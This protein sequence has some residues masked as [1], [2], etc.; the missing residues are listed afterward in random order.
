MI[1]KI[2][3]SLLV[4]NCSA[5]FA[6]NDLT[7]IQTK[8]QQTR[9]DLKQQQVSRDQL[10]HNLKETENQLGKLTLEQQKISV[11][12]K[13]L[14]A[15]LKQ[16]QQQQTAYEAELADRRADLAQ[17]IRLAYMLG[18]QPSLKL[19]LSHEDLTRVGR[20]LTYYQYVSRYQAEAVMRLNGLLQQLEQNQ[21]E[22]ADKT[23]QLDKLAAQQKTTLAQ[24]G[25]QKRDRTQSLQQLEGNIQSKNS[26]LQ[27]L[28]ADKAALEEAV[29]KANAATQSV[30]GAVYWPVGGSF[31]KAQGKLSWP[32]RGKL[33][34]GFDSKLAQSE[35]KLN[36]VLIAAAEGQP[37]YSV[38]PGRVAFAEW[39]SGYGLLMIV[40][41]GQGYMTLY[42][43]NGTLYKKVG[44]AVTAG[45]QIATV[46]KTGGYTQPSLYFAIRQQGTA[47]NPQAW[48]R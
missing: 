12:Q 6:V 46:G 24:I 7:T 39:L 9:Q 38:A 48:C 45:E 11:Q 33:M 43:R 2:L 34:A 16:L 35:L 44:D 10:Q 1:K 30:G 26:Q 17:K 14:Q 3:L 13:A 29:R 27:K 32:T 47:L 21:Q 31:A 22:M 37:V 25:T 42:G 40:D 8:I 5:I 19:L 41:H 4:F 23:A 15:S 20:D 18:D 28:L 36:G